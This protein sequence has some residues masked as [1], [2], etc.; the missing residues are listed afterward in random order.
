MYC[1]L[2]GERVWVNDSL[3]V[4]I[5]T[6]TDYIASTACIS[7]L[8][9]DGSGRIVPFGMLSAQ[10]ELQGAQVALSKQPSIWDV[11]R[12]SH[13]CVKAAQ[14]LMVEVRGTIESTRITIEATRMRIDRSDQL[15]WRA[16][17]LD[18][19]R[20]FGRSDRLEAHDLAVA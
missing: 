17:T 6:Q 8:E 19:D 4:F 1:P 15:V 7:P 5:V 18:C 14:A 3:D 12:S 2:V 10:P 20:F 16:R 11:I 13:E 9:E